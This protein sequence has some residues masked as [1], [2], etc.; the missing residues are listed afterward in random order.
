M[1]G[2]LHPCC[3]NNSGC[4]ELSPDI[5]SQRHLENLPLLGILHNYNIIIVLLAN[6]WNCQQPHNDYYLY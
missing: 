4:I 5:S 2:S 3:Y 1:K 6:K